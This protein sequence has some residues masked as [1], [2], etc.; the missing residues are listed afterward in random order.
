MVKIKDKDPNFNDM[1]VVKNLL[2]RTFSCRDPIQGLQLTFV[3]DNHIVNIFHWC[4]KRPL[5][6]AGPPL[7]LFIINR[8]AIFELCMVTCL[9]ENGHQ[10]DM[11]KE[12]DY[13]V[14]IC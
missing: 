14:K 11:F 2:L 5:R 12:V 13:V 7:S 1:D 9:S 3:V 10:K 8:T 6:N 4:G